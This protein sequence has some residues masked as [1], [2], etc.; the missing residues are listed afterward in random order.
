[1]SAR[2]GAM[3]PLFMMPPF[4]QNVLA[5]ATL[6]YWS[7]DGLLGVLWRDAGLAGI[8]LNLTVLGGI[9]LVML[10]LSLRRF[11]RGDLFR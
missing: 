4:I 1:M 10:A 7:M 6:V 5:P 9:S 2:G 3:F 11:R 8:A